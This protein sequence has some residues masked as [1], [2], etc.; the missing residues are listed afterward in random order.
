MAPSPGTPVVSVCI[1]VHNGEAFVA[2][3]IRSVLDQGRPD[4]E[5]VVRDN[6]STDG[7]WGILEALAARH[8][9]IAVAR[10]AANIGMAPNWNAVVADARGD[11]VMLLSADDR[12]EP[13]FLARCLGE[14]GRGGADIVTTNFYWFRD[15]A[16]T[17]R[18]TFV[19]G[20]TRGSFAATVLL[21]N[22]F[23]IN[24]TLFRR[25]AV[26]RLSRGG[27]LFSSLFFN[28]DYDLWIRAALSGMSLRYLDEPLGAYRV[29][30]SNLSRD[31]PRMDRQS[32][33]VVLRHRRALAA[34]C[35]LAYR[36][37]LARFMGRTVLRRLRGGPF[38]RRLC[39]VLWRES[40]RR[41]RNR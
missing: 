34:A 3:A 14:L 22:P 2:E 23:Q 18:R 29:H 36:A 37:T 4:T 12:L 13:G 25:E 8:P 40:L 9:R 5:I 32:A 30:A 27:N 38:D 1:P 39:S 10:N 6:A 20:G 26:L 11:H 21:F 15:G 41:R 7:T 17:R 33:L 35:P 19:R 31:L 24:F 28:C 16:R